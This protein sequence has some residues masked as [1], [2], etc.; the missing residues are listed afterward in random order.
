MNENSKQV[1]FAIICVIVIIA[2]IFRWFTYLNGWFVR[3]YLRFNSVSSG[4]PVGYNALP[5]KYSD[6]YNIRRWRTPIAQGPGLRQ[7]TDDT[8]AR[9]YEP[10]IGFQLG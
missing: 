3:E 9:T 4:H 2:I 10:G 1:V 7:V 6:S 5:K 8:W